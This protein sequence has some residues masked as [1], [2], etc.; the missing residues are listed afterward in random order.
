MISFDPGTGRRARLAAWGLAGVLLGAAAGAVIA[1]GHERVEPAP[2]SAS[3][4]DADA[5]RYRYAIAASVVDADEASTIA[6]L[7]ARNASQPSPFDM[8]ELAERYLRRAQRDGDRK[9]FDAAAAMAERSL[10]I[11]R[12][13]NPAL[14]TSAKVAS[15]RHDFARAIALAREQLAFKRTSGAYVVLATAQLAIGATGDAS[16]SASAAIAIK[17]DTSAYLTRALVLQ[18]QGR[19]A[20]AGYD[21]AHAAA[22]EEPGDLE[23]AA[24]LRALWGR[25]LV[26]RGDVIG[27][28]AVLAE[29]LRVA[30]G[31]PLAVA[32]QGEL[33]LRSGR[34]RDAVA[35]FD[36][37]FASSRQVRYLIDEA[38]ALESAGDRG[39]ADAV[40]AQVED[41]V[42]GELADG[43]L[44]HRLDLVEVLVDRGRAAALA[45]A[46][47]LARE[48]VARRPSADTRF[49]LARALARTGDRDGAMREVDAALATGAREAALYELAARLEARRGNG[50][51]AAMYAHEADRLD[52]SRSGWR[53]IGMDP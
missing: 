23:G 4:L 18:A 13:P 25:F 27:A 50:A 31:F 35:L 20:E 2:V 33:A 1:R 45:E 39:G 32:Q 34:A 12:T 29:A 36:Q 38:R 17:A 22:L 19:D 7:E 9:D 53:A 15:A 11:L 40:R 51:R 37:A 28:R 42:R 14:L 46:V 3:A 10:A 6:A 30:P 5:A 43:G 52:P 47:A 16:A 8:A 24:R 26:R 41:I 48:E 21:F 44:G 49:Q